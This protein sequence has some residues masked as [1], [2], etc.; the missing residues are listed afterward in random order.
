MN[1]FY[2]IRKYKQSN[3]KLPNIQYIFIEP[4][5][6]DEGLQSSNL[7]EICHQAINFLEGWD[8]SVSSMEQVMQDF[9]PV[10]R[11]GVAVKEQLELFEQAPVPKLLLKSW[12]SELKL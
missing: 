10:L 1:N 8:V 7:K 12:S 2:K 4:F 11:T 6:P 3:F 5:R 9:Q